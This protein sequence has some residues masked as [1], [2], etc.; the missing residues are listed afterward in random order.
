MGLRRD[1]LRG[2]LLLSLGEGVNYGSSFIRNM[3]LARLLTR[4]DFGIAAAFAMI[5]TL[6]EFSGKLGVARF[7]IRDKEAGEPGYLDTAHAVQAGAGVLSA[8]LM[9]VGAWP[10]AALF[11]LQGHFAAL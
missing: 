2:T 3:V 8:L 9:L 5:I 11:E 4:E 6:L 10:L 7:L 1:S